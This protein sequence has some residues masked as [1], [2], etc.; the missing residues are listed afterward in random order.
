MGS[1]AQ[2]TLRYVGSCAGVALT[3]AIATGTGG[4]LAHGTDV[5]MTVSAGLAILGAVGVL[6]ALG[7]ART[8]AAARGLA[9]SGS[10]DRT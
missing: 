5:A 8:A 6:G 1:G 9:T 2:Q 4:G 3:I 7:V 10:R